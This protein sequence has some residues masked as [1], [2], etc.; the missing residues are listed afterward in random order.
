MKST[1]VTKE[2]GK[3]LK[4]KIEILKNHNIPVP[5]PEE[6]EEKEDI[7]FGGGELVGLIV[8]PTSKEIQAL[9]GYDDLGFSH[10]RS[11]GCSQYLPLV[12]WCSKL[13]ESTDPV[14]RMIGW[15]HLGDRFMVRRPTGAIFNPAEKA[16]FDEAQKVGQHL[17]KRGALYPLSFPAITVIGATGPTTLPGHWVPSCGFREGIILQSFI[18]FMDTPENWLKKTRWEMEGLIP[19]I[20]A[21]TAEPL[22]GYSL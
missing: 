14:D 8:N 6:V 1:A 20:E 11:Y 21:G 4:E 5:E 15:K 13:T 18:D 3:E 12:Q 17:L 22:K 19:Q 2:R 16:I 10:S 7:P 9:Q